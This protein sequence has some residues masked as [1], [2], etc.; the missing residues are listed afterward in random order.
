MVSTGLLRGMPTDPLGYDYKLTGNG[1]VLLRDPDDLPFV[2]K[3][4]PD[5]YVA[6]VAP[7]IRPVD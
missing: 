7:K 5:G 6:P 2:E 4:L 3:G 1:R